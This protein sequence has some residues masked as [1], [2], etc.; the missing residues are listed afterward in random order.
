MAGGDQSHM[1][2]VG[3]NR[4]AGTGLWQNTKSR[5]R[6]KAPSNLIKG[7]WCVDDAGNRLAAGVRLVSAA[8]SLHWH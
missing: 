5:Q 7:V 2:L 6:G 1:S 3:N 4:C 8:F